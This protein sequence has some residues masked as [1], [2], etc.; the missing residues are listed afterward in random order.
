MNGVKFILLGNSSVGK[1]SIMLSFTGKPVRVTHIST[2]GIDMDKRLFEYQ[3]QEI[4]VTVWDTAGQ[5]KY[6]NSLPRDLFNRLNGVLLVYDVTNRKSFNA[7]SSWVKIIEE[8][9]PEGTSIVLVGN[10]I[11]KS[12]H[13]VTEEEGKE[14]GRSFQAPFV[15]TSAK[16]GI[17]VEAAFTELIKE[18][19]VKNPNLFEHRQ[20]RG[21]AIVPDRKKNKICC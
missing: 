21:V 14:L 20:E 2:I 4:E 11:D 15:L 1:T 3:G 18:V 17:N 19:L 6:K 12:N 5:E 8:K 7:V 16:E 9:A 10:K 13:Q